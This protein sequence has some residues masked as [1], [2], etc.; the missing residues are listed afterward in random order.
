[1]LQRVAREYNLTYTLFIDNPAPSLEDTMMMFHSAVIIVGPHG[2]GLT[3]MY[4]FQPG[5]YIVEGVC[6][7]PHVNMC[8]QRLAEILGHHW[9]GVTSRRGCEDIVDVSAT[10]VYKAVCAYLRFW[11]LQRS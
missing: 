5:T 2:A 1:M 3:N 11:K 7:L 4:F 10:D 9:H 8:Y 6:N